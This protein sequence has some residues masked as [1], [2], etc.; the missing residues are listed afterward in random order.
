MT[1]EVEPEVAVVGEFVMSDGGEVAP[2]ERAKLAQAQPGA[3]RVFFGFLAPSR[4]PR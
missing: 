1:V 2:P 4:F 3:G